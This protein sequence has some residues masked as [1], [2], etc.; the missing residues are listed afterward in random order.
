MSAPFDV[1][2]GPPSAELLEVSHQELR[3]IPELRAAA[4]AELRTLLQ[5]A[6]DLSFPD[7]EEF[8]LIYLRPCHFYAESAL[9]LMRN[10]AEFQKSHHS[11]LHNLVPTDLKEEIT[12][13]DLVTVLTNRDQKGRRIVVVRVGG[14]W[15]PKLVHED[16]IF[17]ILYTFQKLAVMEPATQINGIVVIYDFDGLGM[18]QVKGMSPGAAKRLLTFIQEA[19]PVR[20]KAVHFTKEPLLFNMVWALMKPFVKEKLKNR[21]FF[22]GADMKKLH[23]HVDADCLPANYGGTLPVLNYGSKDWYPALEKHIDFINKFNA[24][25]Y[26]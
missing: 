4:V 24:A 12:N 20:I 13:H 9:K 16:K 1:E 3:E 23:K 26:K 15:D 14:V 19:A 25:G 8:L 10:V 18:K 22:H 2:L 5:A 21:M 7:D 17:A 11:L 6:S